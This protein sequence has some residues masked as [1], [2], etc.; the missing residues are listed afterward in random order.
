ME[1]KNLSLAE[2]CQEVIQQRL[3]AL[4]GDGGLIAIDQK[5]NI[6]LEFNTEGMYRGQRTSDGINEV[7]IYDR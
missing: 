3:K 4:N 2:A 1:Y 6:V 5:G 7:G